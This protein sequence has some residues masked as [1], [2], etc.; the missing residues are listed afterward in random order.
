MKWSVVYEKAI[1]DDGSLY[2][3]Q[4]LSQEFLESQKRAQG[5]YVFSNQYLN[6]IIPK[7]LQSFKREWF[8]YYKELP[9]R[10]NTFVFV[11]PAISQADTAD[12]TGVAVV[13]VDADKRWYIRFARRY[14]A[15]PTQVIDLLFAL[16]QEFNPQAI[17]IEEVAY[18]KAL[19][20]FLDEE[21]RRRNILLPVKGIKPPNNKTKEMRILALVPR[22]EFGHVFL[23][24]GLED[25]ELELVKFPRAAHDDLADALAGI[26]YIYY[27][28]EKEKRWEKPPA[29]NHPD[30]E[31]WYIETKM[32]GGS[33]EQ[34]EW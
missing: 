25:L 16:N 29:P 17:G 9:Q 3:P 4:K 12:F 33:V 19:L 32:K 31:K 34:T 27:P 7:E 22:F 23:N 10:L 21:M 28:P 13:S 24:H 30:Y 18:Q 20:Y 8:H 2:F 1:R 14:K 26:E 11:D 6:E 5:S 15:T